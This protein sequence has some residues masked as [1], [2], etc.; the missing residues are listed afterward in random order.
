MINEQLGDPYDALSIITRVPAGE[1][2]RYSLES[3]LANCTN[4]DGLREFI[5]L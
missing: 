1:Q 4:V 2:G 5:I 3:L